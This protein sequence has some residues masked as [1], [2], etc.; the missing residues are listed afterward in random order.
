MPTMGTPCTTTDNTIHAFH[1]Y[2]NKLDDTFATQRYKAAHPHSNLGPAIRTFGVT[3][4]DA[5][6]CPK[7]IALVREEAEFHSGAKGRPKSG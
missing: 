5:G 3:E 1:A 6:I 7:A 4:D 2:C